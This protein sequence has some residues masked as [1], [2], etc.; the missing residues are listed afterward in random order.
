[1]E[2]DSNIENCD[3][4]KIW[5][6]IDKNYIPCKVEFWSPFFT[7]KSDHPLYVGDVDE[8]EEGKNTNLGL[9]E[10]S[11]LVSKLNYNETLMKSKFSLTSRSSGS[12]ALSIVLEV[13]ERLIRSTKLS[14]D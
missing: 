5:I 1:M 4:K 3:R 2:R 8:F 9:T 12:V 11:H 6:A 7:H 14:S 10:S 13:D